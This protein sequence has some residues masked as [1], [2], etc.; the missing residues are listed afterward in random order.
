MKTFSYPRSRWNRI[1]EVVVTTLL[2]NISNLFLGA[3]LRSWIYPF[4]FKRFDNSTYIQ[5]GVEL[6]GTHAIEIGMNA[7]LFKGVRIDARGRGNNVCI[8]ADACL[9][10]DVDIRA[11]D[12]TKIRIGERTFIGPFV[13]MAGPGSIDIG[14]DCSIAAHCGIFANNH[15]FQD[16]NRSPNSQGLTRKGVI[17]ERECWIGHAVSIL[18]GVTIGEGSVVGAGSVVIEDIPPKSVVVGVPARVIKSRDSISEDIH[19]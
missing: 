3:K 7:H 8:G 13:C 15:K 5:K 19:A 16:P 18:D 1:R 17:I 12:S 9:Q 10:R 4:V 11:L 14:D 2:G 6:L